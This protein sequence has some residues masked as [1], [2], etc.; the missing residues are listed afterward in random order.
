MIVQ[1]QPALMTPA[2]RTA[3]LGGLLA[4]GY[5]RLALSRQNDLEVEGETERSCASPVDRPKSKMTKEVA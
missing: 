1:K 4:A 5:R 2:A 3:E